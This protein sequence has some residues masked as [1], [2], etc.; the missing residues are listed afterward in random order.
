MNGHE[1]DIPSA[2]EL[3]HQH[4]ILRVTN[5]QPASFTTIMRLSS[6]L[7]Q[8]SAPSFQVDPSGPLATL[9]KIL[10]SEE[11]IENLRNFLVTHWYSVI[12]MAVAVLVLMVR[13]T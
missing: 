11:S 4:A 8:N 10:L 9:R 6:F 13:Q 12:L 7:N 5:A 1:S 3:V 2:V